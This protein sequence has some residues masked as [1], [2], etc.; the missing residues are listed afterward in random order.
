MA[1]IRLETGVVHHPKVME[2]RARKQYRA[3]MGWLLSM[4]LSAAQGSDGLITKSS[5][6]LL[7]I[8]T[9]E[10]NQL[11]D[12]GLWKPVQGGYEINDWD[13]YNPQGIYQKRSKAGK[14]GACSRWH[15][16]NCQDPACTGKPKLE[17]INN[18]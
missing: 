8:T 2:L 1:W 3:V 4:P 17:A 16:P 11:I 14:K 10:A 18:G 9:K 5:L 13:E 15:G 7:D 6:P 12:V